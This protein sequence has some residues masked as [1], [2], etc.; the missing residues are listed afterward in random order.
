MIVHATFNRDGSTFSNVTFFAK[1]I[2]E[3]GIAE[4]EFLLT[5]A[6][7]FPD[8]VLC[9]NDNGKSIVY[10]GGAMVAFVELMLRDET[11]RKN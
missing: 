10:Q 6:K 2:S 8:C 4:W 11:E 9:I 7:A 3:I 1:K 5:M